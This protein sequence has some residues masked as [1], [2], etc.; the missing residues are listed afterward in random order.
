MP[1]Q[2]SGTIQPLV[3]VTGHPGAQPAAAGRG[4]RVWWPLPRQYSP[5]PAAACRARARCPASWLRPPWESARA[6][7]VEEALRL[8]VTVYGHTTAVAER[9]SVLLDATARR[10]VSRF[11]IW[12]QMTTR[13]RTSTRRR[14]NVTSLPG[15]ASG[16]GCSRRRGVAAHRGLLAPARA[17][18]D[19][20]PREAAHLA[21]L[22]R[23]Q[24][25]LAKPR[26]PEA[27][28]PRGWKRSARTRDHRGDG[29]EPGRWQR[30]RG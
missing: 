16:A 17:Q 6:M 15:P 18:C 4:G 10:G 21:R 2:P 23:S 12:L 3:Q 29:V 5:R 24:Y 30:H 14:S 20:C 1:V 25:P 22:G 27:P 9:E 19:D 8:E 28:G 26:C 11:L 13:P 7:P